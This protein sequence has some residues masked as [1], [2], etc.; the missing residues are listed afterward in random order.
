MRH[1]I[2]LCIMLLLL[3]N[4]LY[5]AWLDNIP[6]QLKQPDGTTIDIFY[7]GDEHHNWIH[8]K[9]HYTMVRDEKTGYVCWATTKDGDLVSTG[10]LVHLHTP[11]SLGISPK[12]NISEERYLQKRDLIDGSLADHPTRTPTR[13]TINELVIFIRFL[14]ESEF[15][16]P[17]SFFYDMFNA[18]GN[19]VSSLK[20]YYLDNSYGLLTVNSP[21]YPIPS[22]NSIVSYQDI[23][24]R[25]Y[26]QPYNAVTNPNGYHDDNYIRAMRE[27]QLL[28][29]AVSFI[30]SQI[31]S[32]LNIDADND[33][34]ID[35]VNFVI[36][37]NEGDWSSLLWPHRWSL[38]ADYASI[39]GREVYAYN[40]NIENH[41]I[42]SG[43]SVLAHEFG[44]SLG[45]P[46]YYRYNFGATSVGQWDIMDTNTTP[47][48]AMSAY[49]K[50]FYMGWVDSI[51]T[52]TY[53][54][55]YT[56]YPNTV[57]SAE[58]S[59][60]IP[61]PHSSTEYFIVEYRSNQTGLLDSALHGSGLVVWR[62]NENMAFLGNSQ[63]PP[64]EIY[65]FRKNGTPS[66]D[67]S[68]ALAYLSAQS[69]RTAI[70]SFTNPYPFLSNGQPG[71]LNIYDI[72]S[73][74]ETIT[75]YV[76]VDDILPPPVFAIDPATFDFGYVSVNQSST[77]QSFTIT[78]SGGVTID[79]NSIAM[80]GANDTDFD[81]SVSG[82]PWS[83]DASASE[84]FYVTFTP[85]TPGV[86]TAYIAISPTAFATPQYV[87]LT[88]IG[89]DYGFSLPYAQSFDSATDL[90]AIGW[91]DSL[92]SYS[93][94]RDDCGV[95]DTYGLVLNVRSNIPKQ[96]VQTPTIADIT[97]ST[98]LS[99]SYRV[100]NYPISHSWSDGFSEAILSAG[101]KVCIDISTVGGTGAYT[102]IYE[103]NHTNHSSTTNFTTI[104][105]PLSAYSAQSVNI[106][107]RATRATGNWV[108]MLDDVHISEPI[109]DFDDVALP[110]IATL[111]GNYPNP[112]NP[113]TVIHF[114][115]ARPE[116]VRLDI[117]SVRGQLV[118]SLVNS[119]YN[120][121]LHT[122]VWN[123]CDNL[124]RP[125]SSGVYFY[126]MT[127][128]EYVSVRKMLLLK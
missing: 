90:R 61:S 49:T 93:G 69:G 60:K 83:L 117:F 50:W 94:I 105:I 114:S 48:Q 116:K 118:R 99:F 89:D 10:K 46:D 121:G 110:A 96:Y 84:T 79:V 34:E 35:N 78:N 11:Q 16:Q 36:R 21:F 9:D 76:N 26:Y 119:V 5:P 42:V 104:N 85:S 72:G 82:L 32:T 37:G 106:R 7:S 68:T 86:K 20:Q 73:A 87:S 77:T 29:R 25:S 98:S 62:I 8:D 128:S 59:L 14:G 30:A 18:T 100:V 51:P 43:V 108:F 123:G 4:T 115:L 102:T 71:G 97:P 22:G 109:A 56:L 53:S 91:S 17:L 126:R 40:F 124:G 80:T 54:D 92:S 44:H 63:G 6:N 41:M 103:I 66:Y 125:V 65:V 47:P 95:D 127:T 24:P 74:E 39:N 23:Y 122:T 12:E 107:F 19:N 1:T 3:A 70:N 27:H 75:F 15:T 13:G 101:D 28:A 81:L 33:W 31:P 88:G 55:Y 52:V 38:W 57:S 112:F 67:G 58:H 120:A 45:A 111:I 64:D 113:E 2:L